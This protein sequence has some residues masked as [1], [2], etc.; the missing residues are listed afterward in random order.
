MQIALNAGMRSSP[1]G[2]GGRFDPPPAFEVRV[3][4]AGGDW[5]LPDFRVACKASS[6]TF[7]PRCRRHR[8]QFRGTL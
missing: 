5:L 2:A 3:R 1:E 4:R 6:G 7:A 8:F